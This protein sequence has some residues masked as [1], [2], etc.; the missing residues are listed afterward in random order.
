MAEHLVSNLCSYDGVTEHHGND[1]VLTLKELEAFLAHA[2]AEQGCVLEEA[3]AEL[4]GFWTSSIAL[5][6]AAT[7]AGA[8]ELEKR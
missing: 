4:A 7:M 5:M 1:G 6:V 3:G 2:A 8:V